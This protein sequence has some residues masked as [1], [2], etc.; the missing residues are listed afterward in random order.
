M[1]KH[2]SL[3]SLVRKCYGKYTKA[4]GKYKQVDGKDVFYL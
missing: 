4:N 1:T 3:N 2:V